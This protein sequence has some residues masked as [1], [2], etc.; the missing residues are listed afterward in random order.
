MWVRR[1][2]ETGRIWQELTEHEMGIALKRRATPQPDG[3]KLYSVDAFTVDVHRNGEIEAVPFVWEPREVQRVGIAGYGDRVVR[4]L[5]RCPVPDIRVGDYVTMGFMGGIAALTVRIGVRALVDDGVA[6][7][8]DWNGFRDRPGG[9][10]LPD[11]LVFKRSEFCS[12]VYGPI[13]CDYCD[14]QATLIEIHGSDLY[15][16][17]CAKNNFNAPSESVKPLT[18]PGYRK[19]Y[20]DE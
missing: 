13:A 17:S 4:V 14:R 7:E 18:V 15:C 12:D 19:A 1:D 20:P 2:P 6:F 3:M 5:K 11:G 10:L 9:S 16:Q 8:F